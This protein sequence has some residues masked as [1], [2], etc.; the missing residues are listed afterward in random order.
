MTANQIVL[1]RRDLIATDVDIGKFAE[2]SRDAVYD[3][4][5]IDDRLND[6]PRPRHFLLRIGIEPDTP[7]IERN[8][9]DVLDGE[10]LTVDQQRIHIRMISRCQPCLKGLLL[11]RTK[12]NQLLNAQTTRTNTWIAAEFSFVPVMVHE[13]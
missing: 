3:L 4:I 6:A 10:A 2:T 1:Q 12:T 9:V 5:S 11:I 8:F 13:P 7:P